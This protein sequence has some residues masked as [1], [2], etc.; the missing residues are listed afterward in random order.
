[1]TEG[2]RHCFKGGNRCTILERD[3]KGAIMASWLDDAIFY[4]IYPQSFQ[5]SNGDG[6]GDLPGLIDRLDYVRELGCNAIWINPCFESPFM[7]AGYDVSDYCRV[8][9]R[10]GTNE[11]MR[12]L[13]VAAHERGLKVMLDLVPGHTSIDHP[14]FVESKKAEPNPY[15]HRYIWTDSIWKGLDGVTSISGSLRGISDRD[16][17][18]ACNF[19]TTQPALNYGFAAPTESWQFAYTAPEALATREAMKDVMRFWLKLGCDGFRVDMAGSL[20]KND[21]GA[22][23]TIEVWRDFR[24]FLDREF[25][26]AAM[27]SEWGEPDKSL[28]DGFQMDFLLH[29]GPSHYN[30][31]FRCPEPFFSRRGLG[32]AADFLAYYESATAASNGKGLICIPSGNHDM[33]R[34]A[35]YLDDAERRL[36]FAFLLTMPGAPFVYYGDEIGMRHIVELRS[37]EGGY[38]RTGARTP[39][40][41]DDGVNA[42]FS[43]AAPNALYIQQDPDERRPTVNQALA[44][45]KSLLHE[46]RALIALR[47][48]HVSLQNLST[49]TFLAGKGAGEPLVY[50]RDSRPADASAPG[51]GHAASRSGESLLVAINPAGEERSCHL[52]GAKPSKL[53]KPLWV[54]GAGAAAGRSPELV[55]DRLTLPAETAYVWAVNRP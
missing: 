24:A 29:F 9:P 38:A 22:K 14:W 27:I 33:G 50:R 8:A 16:G 39:M 40:Q 44:D 55:G 3:A 10:Y 18:C 15:S 35:S 53:G 41:W 54:S 23:A 28:A 1:M 51:G 42:G 12:R 48:A 20:V 37:V 26:D 21:P 46:I 2:Y 5:D 7:D 30:D 31:L 13:F 11:D 32:N 36:A 19:F 17:S 43:A 52:T 34:L 47:Q 49:V 25:P 6:I 4:E 45:D